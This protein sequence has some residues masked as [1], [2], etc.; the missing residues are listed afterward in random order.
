MTD[1]D[2]KAASG[3]TLGGKDRTPRDKDTPLELVGMGEIVVLL[4]VPKSTVVPRRGVTSWVPYP[5][6]V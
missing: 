1:K 4:N 6:M 5:A 2:K 3:H